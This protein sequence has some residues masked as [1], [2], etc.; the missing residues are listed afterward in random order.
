MNKLLDFIFKEYSL[1]TIACF[2]AAIGLH[3]VTDDYAYF[4]SALAGK[5]FSDFAYF[6]V[7][8]QGYMGIREGYNLFYSWFP[9]IN[10]HFVFAL[11]F[12]W[13]SLFVFLR[14]FRTAAQN[15]LNERSIRILFVLIT[16]CYIENL[17]FISHTRVSLIFCGVA[18]FN[19]AFIE[20]ISVKK[21]GWNT[22]LFL[23]GM[24]LR[25]ESAIGMLVLVSTAFFIYHFQPKNYIKRFG[26]PVFFVSLFLTIFYLDL[27]STDIFVRKIE[28]EIEYSMMA[29]R[30]MPIS[31]MHTAKDSLKYE[32]ARA[33]MWF[34]TKEVSPEFMRSI[35]L[36]GYDLS[37]NHA[38]EVATHVWALYRHYLFIPFF[39]LALL[40]LSISLFT[41][42]KWLLAKI[43]SLMV[44]TFFIIYVLDYNGQLVCNRHF[45][46]MQFIALLLSSF[47]VFTTLV[48][49]NTTLPKWVGASVFI[50]LSI[51]TI[52][53]VP[54]YKIDLDVQYEAETQME[55]AMRKL[56]AT[57]QNRIFA[58]TL[59]SR[60]LFDQHFTLLNR[61]YQSNTYI[62]FDWFTFDLTPR[63]VD[64]KQRNCKCDA[65]NPVELFDWMA[66][67][68]VLYV[69]TPKKFDLTERYMKKVH[70]LAVKF[71][72][73]INVNEWTQT[74]D[75]NTKDC[76]I[77][78]VTI[79]NE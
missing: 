19:L 41:Y 76:E 43:I 60:F 34:D 16:L 63:Y 32:A 45:L 28:P 3:F 5:Q 74:N 25:S 9:S 20:P 48:H 1:A 17:V 69:S 73:P 11:F 4:M 70:G 67:N 58:L 26:L 6:D 10:W 7:H 14:A 31:A 64:F 12:E 2:T 61:M 24:L 75:F 15:K 44:A 50:L 59:E 40:L 55:K 56:E 54:T 68:N 36:P 27:K 62:M 65:N 78:K 77:R 47:F 35:L 49:T 8:F 42:D 18:L 38:I 21:L 22:A 13:L 66:K 46:N 30:V 53:T 51:G 52:A 72:E 37:L 23:L 33:G 39:L 79:A 71:T 29:D 57:F